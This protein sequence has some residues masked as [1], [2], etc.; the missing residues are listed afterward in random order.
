[1]SCHYYL[2]TMSAYIYLFALFLSEPFVPFLAEILVFLAPA[3]NV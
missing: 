1:M 3:M 2:G